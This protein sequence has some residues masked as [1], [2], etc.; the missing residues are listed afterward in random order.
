M[1][2]FM[3]ESYTVKEGSKG[4]LNQTIKFQEIFM[5]D[6]YANIRPV[7]LGYFS[8]SAEQNAKRCFV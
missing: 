7:P 6:L 2:A 4:N 8:S 3:K 1:S 5:D